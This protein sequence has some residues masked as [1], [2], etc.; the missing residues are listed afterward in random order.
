MSVNR[1]IHRKIADIRDILDVGTNIQDFLPKKNLHTRRISSMRKTIYTMM[2]LRRVR[3][4]TL[5]NIDPDPNAT[6]VHISLPMTL[7]SGDPQHRHHRHKIK[8]NHTDI[9][10]S[11]GT[12]M[13][14]T[15]VT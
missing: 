5:D 10:E 4:N 3:R 8:N 1:H 12:K 11:S 9:G 2:I 7:D 6:E 15:L 14:K 13:S